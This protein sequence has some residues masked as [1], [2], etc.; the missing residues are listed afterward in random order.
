MIQICDDL[1]ERVKSDHFSLCNARIAR[2]L[3]LLLLLAANCQNGGGIKFR[4]SVSRK[5]S[6]FSP[7]VGILFLIIYTVRTWNTM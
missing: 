5:W 1:I 2:R 4:Q 3:L 7:R 6:H